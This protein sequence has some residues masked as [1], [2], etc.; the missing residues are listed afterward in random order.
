M[1]IVMSKCDVI[2]KSKLGNIEEETKSADRRKEEKREKLELKSTKGSSSTPF[3][4]Q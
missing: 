3:W 4:Y 1:S 2:E